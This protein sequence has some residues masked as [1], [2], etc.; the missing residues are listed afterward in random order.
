[1][2]EINANQE[3]KYDNL[4][5]FDGHDLTADQNAEAFASKLDTQGYTGSGYYVNVNGLKDATGKD[6]VAALKTKG[7]SLPKL[8]DGAQYQSYPIGGDAINPLTPTVYGSDKDKTPVSPF[9]KD[10]IGSA[11]LWF[12]KDP[13][14]PTP[15]KPGGNGGSSS[16][17]GSS[18]TT[19]KPDVTI[20]NPQ[21]NTDFGAATKPS[22]P[23]LPNY[24]AVKSSSVYALGSIYLYKHATFAKKDRIA[25]YPK[26]KRTERPMFV[27]TDYARSNGGALRYKVRDVNHKSKTAGKTGYITANPKIVT[28][29][30]YQSVPKTKAI[31]VLGRKG[32]NSYHNETLTKKMRHYKKGT[33][34]KV[35]K[36]VNHNLTTRYQLTNGNYVS[37]NKK[38]VYQVKK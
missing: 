30:Y 38:L 2:P 7:Y 21:S 36:I 18:G 32:I 37:A 15:E 31:Q 34:L 22:T 23:K 9:N 13:V 33:M 14:D 29:V 11:Y 35:K 1:M 24:A 10:G 27:V 12:V 25:H 17:P 6:L 26:Q 8:T 4:D 5:Y 3:L 28:K 20:P 19:I 16:R